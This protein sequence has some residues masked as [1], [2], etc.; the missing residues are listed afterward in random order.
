MTY[1]SRLISKIY[2]ATYM[3]H[4]GVTYNIYGKYIRIETFRICVIYASYMVT[5]YETYK[6]LHVNYMQPHI[7]YM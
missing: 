2:V 6:N 3:S 7:C 5:I 1:M 4:V